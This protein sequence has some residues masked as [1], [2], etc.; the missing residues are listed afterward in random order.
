MPNI[1]GENIDRLATVEMRPATGNLPRGAINRLYDAVRSKYDAPLVTRVVAALESRLSAGDNV[2]I[3][4]GAG[5]PPFLPNSEI[6]GIPGAVSIARALHF[7]YGVQVTILTEARAEG[8]VRATTRAAGMNFR[9]KDENPELAHCVVFE[10]SPIER[11]ACDQHAEDILERLNPT[12]VIAI[13]KLSPNSAGVIHGTTGLSY[14]DVHTKPDAYFSRA[15]ER[16]ILTVGIGDGGNEVG[17]GVAAEET[18][19]IM[20]AGQRCLCEC[21]GGS[22][23]AIAT[24]EFMVAAISDWGGYALGAMIAYTTGVR[25]AMITPRDVERML[26]ACI[27]AGALDGARGTPEVGDDGVPLEGQIAYVSL[28]NTLVDVASATLESP[29]H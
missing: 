24:D 26:Y 13:E 27:D 21:G 5:G 11:D 28:L 12:A 29:G 8:S 9:R 6:D 3:L 25:K 22:A 16:D 23:A 15:A 19:K 2:V 10:A 20:P 1:I 17:F 7:G 14:D 4:T 18:A